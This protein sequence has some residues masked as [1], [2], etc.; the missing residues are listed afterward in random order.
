MNEQKKLP[1]VLLVDDM[2]ANIKVLVQTLRSD[3]F[4]SVATDGERALQLAE[5]EKPDLILLDIMMPGI[6]GYEVCRRLKENP[7][8]LKIPVI[9]ITSKDDVADEM[10]GL[11]LGAVDYITKPFSPVI[12][13]ARV[14]TQVGLKKAREE[15]EG[16]KKDLER[17]NS[18]IRN[19]FGRYMSD[20][21]VNTLLDTP[22]GL[23]LGGE[24][25]Q[26][27]VV[28]S[29]LRGFSAICE[30]LSPQEV[31]AILN[32]Y[33]KVMTN[34]I[35]RHN[36]TI[37]ELMGDGILTLFGAPVMRQ[38]D[39]Q[40]AVACALEMQQ[41]MGLVNARN[42]EKGF[43]A[44]RMGIGI[45]A[46]KVVVGNIGSE[47]RSKYGVVG[48][49]INLAARI[50]SYAVGGQVLVS[51]SVQELCNVPLRIDDW[52]QV[53]PKGVIQP[54]TIYAAGGI[55]GPY[56]L[57]L[58]KPEEDRLQEIPAG[59]MA[60]FVI[61]EEK[62][63][64]GNRHEG[65]VVG[66]SRQEADLL[67]EVHIDRFANLKIN[68]YQEGRQ[69]ASEIYGKMVRAGGGEPALFRIVFTSTPPEAEVCIEAIVKG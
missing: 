15:I 9:F 63:V 39:G 11:A 67:T 46:G 34:I 26:V 62:N 2:P 36:G 57:Y 51:E 14:N 29:D 16:Q 17:R 20:E 53:S 1:R 42:R 49:N 10:K 27:V 22:D 58:P 7:K 47:K 37:I 61:L 33:L 66:L 13:K 54:I 59:L 28:M 69:V 19:T 40:R 52:F 41:A 8:T 38:D 18:F 5:S 56:G 24:L 43:P 64:G 48:T 6:D 30:W 50:E 35:L 44:L 4:I 3:H 12:V 60:Q 32:M 55:G 25:K 45:N 68:L 65:R 23:L 21:V 31:M